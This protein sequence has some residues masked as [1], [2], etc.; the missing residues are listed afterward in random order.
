MLL[1]F[2]YP[3]PLMYINYVSAQTL[4]C[5]YLRHLSKQQTTEFVNAVKMNR[6]LKSCCLSL[7]IVN[8]IVISV[9][10][11]IIIPGLVAVK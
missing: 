8:V 11:I 5:L 1:Y 6:R 2:T 3:L 10:I 4:L 9:V 7:D